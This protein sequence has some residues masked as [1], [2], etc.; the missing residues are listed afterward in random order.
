MTWNSRNATTPPSAARASFRTTR[1]LRSGPSTDVYSGGMLWSDTSL[2]N[3]L[4][5]NAGPLSKQDGFPYALTTAK[6]NAETV[7]NGG[8]ALVQ[9]EGRSA[10]VRGV[11]DDHQVVQG[12]VG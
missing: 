11:I 1:P 10:H 6:E 4:L 5:V 12:A 2:W 8:L 7:G 9:H 3:C